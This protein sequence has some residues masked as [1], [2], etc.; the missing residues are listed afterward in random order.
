MKKI[1]LMMFCLF[2]TPAFA[3]DF[4]ACNVVEIVI[5]GEKN[6]HIQLNCVVVN[7]P[8]CAAGSTFV[9]FDKSTTAGK[10][11]LALFTTAFTM[12]MKVTGFV[13]HTSCPV[14]QPNVSML[15]HLRVT[16]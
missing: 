8:A 9:G 14:W 10:Q 3:W 7:A 5:T 16:K 4:T 15:T 12:N 6:A 1:I 2:T 11:Y 13:D